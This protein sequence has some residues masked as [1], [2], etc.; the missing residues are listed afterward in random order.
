MTARSGDETMEMNGGSAVPYLACTPYVPSFLLLFIGL[1]NGASGLPGETWDRFRCTVE[2]LPCHI[3]C[4]LVVHETTICWRR[5]KIKFNKVICATCSLQA[6][7]SCIGSLGPVQLGEKERDGKANFGD[8]KKAKCVNS[9]CL[10]CATKTS[11]LN[12][13]GQFLANFSRF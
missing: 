5:S 8:F 9:P 3:Q 12:D 7:L 1:E 6:W 10:N 2:S 11:L 13:F 4:H